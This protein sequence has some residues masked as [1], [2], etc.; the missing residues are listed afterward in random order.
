MN[1]YFKHE[2]DIWFAVFVFIVGKLLPKI[3]TV[4]RGKGHAIPADGKT[5]WS[6]SRLAMVDQS[7]RGRAANSIRIAPILVT[8]IVPPFAAAIRKTRET[9]SAERESRYCRIG[10]IVFV[11]GG[12]RRD[13]RSG[14]L[15]P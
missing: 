12:G 3:S 15:G 5:S 1:L 2:S 10:S 11:G 13:T 7:R 6:I 14:V 4:F 9:G 8:R